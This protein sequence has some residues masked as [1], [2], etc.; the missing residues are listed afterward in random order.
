MHVLTPN[1]AEKEIDAILA[2]DGLNVLTKE[3]VMPVI[4]NT[5]LTEIE[6]PELEKLNFE[7][8]KDD[9]SSLLNIVKNDKDKEI[10]DMMSVIKKTLPKKIDEI[11]SW[12]DIEYKNKVVTYIYKADVDTTKYSKEDLELLANSIQNEACVNAYTT[13]C[14]K[15]KPMFIDAGIN[16]QI[17]Y[18]DKTDKELSSCEFNETTCKQN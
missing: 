12:I 17:R 6:L 9:A 4:G 3:D 16:M 2:E 15:I 11:T 8:P 14:P 5:K 10:E 7:T 1:D 18:V 13:M